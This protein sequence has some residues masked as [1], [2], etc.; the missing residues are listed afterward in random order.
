MTRCANFGMSVIAVT[1][2][3]VCGTYGDEFKFCDKMNHFW[4]YCHCCW[5]VVLKVQFDLCC[6]TDDV[7]VDAI[8]VSTNGKLEAGSYCEKTTSAF[9]VA[10]F[11][12]RSNLILHYT[13]SDIWV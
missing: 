3:N 2:V 1:S 13:G 4:H 10:N 9:L 8:K 12:I 11:Q 7:Q 5:N 6:F